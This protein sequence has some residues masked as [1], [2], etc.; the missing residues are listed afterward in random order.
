MFTQVALVCLSSMYIPQRASDKALE[1]EAR[2]VVRF[3]CTKLFKASAELE[4]SL[5]LRLGGGV[6]EFEVAH[7]R[8]LS[9]LLRD[10]AC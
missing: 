3:Q 8:Y 5:A 4:A 9:H 2:G 1:L 10:I 7:K 6:T